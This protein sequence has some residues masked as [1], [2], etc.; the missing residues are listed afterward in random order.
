M[1]LAMR[2]SAPAALGSSGADVAEG[3]KVGVLLLNLGGPDTLDQVEPFLYNL[4]SDPEIITLPGAVRWLNGP[5]A[6]IIAKTRAPMSREGYKQVLDGGSPQLRTTLAQGA[7][8][9]AALSTRGV[10]AKS[11]IGMRYWHPYTDEALAAIKADGVQRLVVLPLYPQ[12]SIS[13]SGSSLRLLEREYYQDEQ[14]RLLKNVVIPAW[15][16]RQGYVHSMARLIASRIDMLPEG[17]RAGAHVF[18]SAHGLPQKYVQELGD[19]YQ[20]QIE[21]TVSFVMARLRVLGY[22]NPDTLAY[23]SKVGPVPWLQP[24]TD[25]KIKELAGGGVS[26]LVVVPI[27]FVS[28]HIETLEEIDIEYR[29]LAEEAGITHWERVPAL[30]V[31][32]DFIED[33]ASAVVEALPRMEQRPLQEIDEGRPVSLRV[34]NDLVSLRSKEEIGAEYGPVRVRNYRR[35]GFTPKAEVING[36]IAMAAITVASLS[37]Y[38]QGDLWDVIYNGRIPFEWF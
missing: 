9:E 25:E 35:V 29:E 3:E 17:E 26:S 13:T 38:L 10:S 14:L 2:P 27:S 21:A 15:Y 36:R 20:Q 7:A 24:Y 34:V 19:P 32:E 12:F 4:F 22:S 23:Q 16:N 37:S 31:E 30:G 1:V 8:I 18:F 6:W 11:Y 33:L 28:E 5:L